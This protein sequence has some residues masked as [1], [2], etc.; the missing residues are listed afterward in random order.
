M[1]TLSVLV[2]ALALANVLLP[3]AP[4]QTQAQATAVF[5][6][7]EVVANALHCENVNSSWARNNGAPLRCVHQNMIWSG[8]HTLC[9]TTITA[10]YPWVDT[11]GFP[12]GFHSHAY[13]CGG[14]CVFPG[15]GGGDGRQDPMSFG[16]IIL[17]A[18]IP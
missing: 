18:L 8:P 7:V 3:A 14:D 11:W 1:K 2:L 6:D 13:S 5:A 17:W 16:R 4:A 15:G 10:T 12:I 9:H